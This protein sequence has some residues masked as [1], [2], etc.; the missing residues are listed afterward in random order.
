MIDEE[1]IEPRKV[2]RRDAIRVGGGG[3][4]SKVEN[5]IG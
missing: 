5:K 1:A 4:E 2:E 3:E